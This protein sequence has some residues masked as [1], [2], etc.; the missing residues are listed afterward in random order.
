M[1]DVVTVPMPPTPGMIDEGYRF[2]GGNPADPASWAK[3]PDVGTVDEGYRFK[4]GD[5]AK[6]ESWEKVGGTSDRL[7]QFGGD[8]LRFGPM[9]PAAAAI[10]EGADALGIGN[11]YRGLR[12][13]VGT[14]GVNALASNAD[15]AAATAPGL[16]ALKSA[17]PSI[18][19]RL[20]GGAPIKDA[21]Y[22]QAG[23]PQVNAAGRGWTTPFGGDLG[24]LLDQGAE[25]AISSM[26]FPGSAANLI[27]GFLGGVASDA[28]GQMTKGSRWE[29]VARML[30]SVVGTAGGAGGQALAGRGTDLVRSLREPFT[31]EGQEAVAGRV[32]QRMATDPKAALAA[33]ENPQTFVPGSTP[34][35]ARLT[36]DPGLLATENVLANTSGRGGEFAALSSENNA[37]RARAIEGVQ[38]TGAVSDARDFFGRQIAERRASLDAEVGKVGA[39]GQAS[40][41]AALDAL[42]RELSN[43]PPGTSARDA[44][45]IIQR[46][47]TQREAILRRLRGDASEPFYT[48]A[49]ESTA[50]IDAGAAVGV[51]NREL[52][53]AAGD[54]RTGIEAALKLFERSGGEPR[55]SVAELMGTDKALGQAINAADRAGNRELSAT[56]SQAKAQLT[57]AL[58]QEPMYGAGK[59][60]FERLSRPLDPYR[61]DR[62]A[63]ILETD[64]Y[65]GRPAM[66]PDMV[67]GRLFKPGPDGGGAVRDFLSTRPGPA[68]TDA[69][70]GDITRQAREAYGE[71]NVTRLSSFI[72]RHQPALTAIDEA[73]PGFLADLR[74]TA[75]AGA[76]VNTAR[77]SASE[78]L[79]AATRLQAQGNALLD[80]SP[81]ARFTQ[82]DP[83]R[84]IGEALGSRDASSRFGRL[85]M[86]AKSDRSGG[87]LDGLRRGVVDDFKDAVQSTTTTVGGDRQMTAAAAVRWWDKNSVTIRQAFEDPQYRALKAIVDDFARDARSAPRVAGSD[88]MRNLQTGRLIT[89]T[90]LEEVLGKRLSSSPLAQSALR[91]IQFLY[92]VPEEQVR[93]LLLDM[94]KDPAMARVLMMKAS[95]GNIKLAAPTIQNH[96]IR[97]GAMSA[98]RE[99]MEAR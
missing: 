94:A 60:A 81:P 12:D 75:A 64:R 52:P 96:L 80:S 20:Y 8:L 9:A 73:R 76:D 98:G 97:S 45:E 31:K 86:E 72:Q 27:P 74:R 47:I 15:T 24:S 25:F 46:G 42:E 5:P 41:R 16:M 99:L 49:R 38:P 82:A 63:P 43:L 18:F 36:N 44:G 14:R 92:R 90:I 40:E 26:A 39:A 11:E 35:T 87:A 28:A 34:T 59:Q 77:T 65:T 53:T 55:G 89:G 13:W 21:A 83:Q 2:N 1:A 95:A 37:A 4:G 85:V 67:P 69:L 48:A 50:P 79:T 51:L 66:A 22:K 10:R 78:N 32:Y 71:G 70:I 56:L 62:V 29:P 7:R 3:I 17:A 6:Q 61:T 93:D 58:G 57:G 30:G 84:A 88:T 91:P 23:L 54:I 19:D 68:S 33:T